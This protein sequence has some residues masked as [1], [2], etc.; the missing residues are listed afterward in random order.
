MSDK[1]ESYPI[2]GMHCASCKTLIERTVGGMHGVDEAKVNYGSEVL[3]VKYDD[4]KV[5]PD[6]IAKS[7]AKVGAYSL[8]TGSSGDFGHEHD[9]SKMKMEEYK[10]L[11]KRVLIIGLAAIPFLILMI[12]MYTPLG[13]GVEIP[14]LNFLQFLLATPILFIGG[15]DIFKSGFTALRNKTA[16]MDTL[17]AIGTSSAWLLSTL[18]TFF[19]TLFAETTSGEVY[20]EAAVFIIFFIMLGRLLEM[21]AKTQ[22]G[23][24][25]KSLIKMQAK[26][27]TV[28]KDGKETQIPIE[29]VK[30]SDLVIVRPGEKIPVDGVIVEGGTTIDESM[31]TGESVPVYK[32]NG[33]TV[34]GATINLTGAIT[35]KTS[36]SPKESLFAQIIKLVEEAQSSEPQIQKLADR[37]SAVFVPSVIVIAIF[38]FLFWIFVGPYI[39]STDTSTFQ[40]AT[41]TAITVLIIACPCALGLATPTA[42]MVSIGE[43][44]KKGILV[45]DANSL[46]LFNKVTHIIF[47]KTGTLTFGSPEVALF[48][49]AN[50]VDE[51]NIK[52][53]I[54]AVEKKSHHPLAQAITK[55]LNV[56][57]GKEVDVKSFED[58]PGKGVKAT[59]EKHEILIGTE[60]LMKAMNVAD[61]SGLMKDEELF[62]NPYTLSYVSMD[63]KLQAVIGLIDKPKTE[64]KKTIENLISLGI[65]PIMLTGD[66]KNVAQ[67]IAKTLG[68]SEVIAEVLPQDK[69]SKV[70]ELQDK[71]Y[72]VAMVGDGIND[73]P[74][75]AQA[76]IGIAMGNGTDIAIET[77]DIVLING[78]IEKIEDAFNISKSTLKVIKENLFW[79]F[80]Y[81]I[82]GIPIAAGI[83]YPFF[84]IL[85][86]PVIASAAMALSSVSV[87]S[88]SLRL[89]R[90]LK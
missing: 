75:L 84:G 51:K 60:N 62:S 74:A 17:I 68:I 61:P 10:S 54:Y 46:E 41:Y 3:T 23:E 26:F 22:T 70:K 67:E 7:V 72:V 21:R 9:H 30:V 4:A 13:M 88:N 73:S 27:A 42:V 47:D 45:K 49:L 89:K 78:S 53:I 36:K 50:D 33:E 38:T 34:I 19:P 6:E 28:I 16:N 5:N 29:Q 59:V 18:V 31:I 87:V 24:A 90:I 66:K 82:I 1:K 20:F 85:L 43:A 15:R 48:K 55:Y 76:D 37:I 64:S 32:E 8:V 63:K 79:A 81:N 71:G 69:S 77:G 25:V 65:M 58:I 11:K 44:A 39:L 14:N 83:L 35:I 80:G 86:S 56:Y 2:V 52:E 57:Q 40:L 12:L